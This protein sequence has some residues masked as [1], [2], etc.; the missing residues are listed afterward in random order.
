[1]ARTFK[2][3]DLAIDNSEVK[4][5]VKELKQ[6]G[7]KDVL[8]TLAKFHR[9]I[10]KEQLQ[11]SR[12][13][14][15][16]QPVPKANR[17]AM[18][19]T[20]SGTRSEAKINIKTSDRYPSA[21]SMEFGRRF[22]YVPTRRGG[23][24]AITQAEIGRLPHSRPGAKFPYRKW[25]GNNRDRG[26]SSFTKLGKQGYVVGKTISRNQNEILETYND[27]LYDALTKAIK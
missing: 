25:I 15:R 16:K 10:A 26:D 3:T 19:F 4:E 2:K 18:G 13:L 5:I 24:R 8:K 6:Y 14:A 23:T 1:M 7:K 17:S 21:L 22:Q 20:A 12:V 9:E 27:R 11:D